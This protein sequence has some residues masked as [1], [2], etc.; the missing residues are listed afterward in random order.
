MNG[1][2][3][4]FTEFLFENP[5]LWPVYALGL[6]HFIIR[7][8]FGEQAAAKLAETTIP[9]YKPVSDGETA[10]PAEI[11]WQHTV[12]NTAYI[13][14]LR[15]TQQAWSEG[16][17]DTFSP[18]ARETGATFRGMAKVFEPHEEAISFAF[19]DKPPEAD[20][21]L[22]AAQ[23]AGTQCS[24]VMTNKYFYFFGLDQG[25]MSNNYGMGKVA[26]SAIEK[27]DIKEGW[28]K[29]HITIHL[30]SGEALLVKDLIED[31]PGRYLNLRLAQN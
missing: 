5:F 26:Y 4:L 30:F 20:E 28:I 16:A 29:N 18:E 15:R 2:G 31:A 8:L 10:D 9:E 14:L 17:L 23:N 1:L 19:K 27:I 25:L 6:W 13:E 24:F 3:N 11:G 21:F 12:G 22:V 7:P